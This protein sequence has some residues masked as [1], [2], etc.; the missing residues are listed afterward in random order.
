ERVSVRWRI[1]LPGAFEYGRRVLS[2]AWNTNRALLMTLMTL[3][4]ITGILPIGS[5]YV[6]Y[7]MVD[8]VVRAATLHRHSGAAVLTDVFTCV[9]L[10]GLLVAV[11]TLAERGTSFT[12]TLLRAQLGQRINV[13]I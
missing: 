11:T 8:A 2:L 6:S 10:M 7:L 5:A 3:V 12:Q 9:A 1:R 4:V 13:M